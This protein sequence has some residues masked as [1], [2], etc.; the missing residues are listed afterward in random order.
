MIGINTAGSSDYQ[1]Q[2]AGGD[3]FA[4]PIDTAKTIADQIRAGRSS[5]KIHLGDTPTWASRRP[6]AAPSRLAGPAVLGVVSGTPADS[7]GLDRGDVISSVA[8][9]TVDSANATDRRPGPLPPRRQG[10]TGLDR[11]FR[12]V[13][14][15][16]GEAGHRPGRLTVPDQWG[17]PLQSGAGPVVV[18]S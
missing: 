7:A 5:N 11:G 18:R 17:R 2:S 8:G 16:L 15:H 14:L 4:I 1:S 9:T 12:P 13:P 3:G 10:Q 6:A